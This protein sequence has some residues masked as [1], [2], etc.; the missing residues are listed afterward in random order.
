MHTAYFYFFPWITCLLIW[1]Y[2]IIP[3][4][5][6]CM[7]ENAGMKGGRE[8]SRRCKVSLRRGELELQNKP[9]TFWPFNTPAEPALECLWNKIILKQECQLLKAFRSDRDFVKNPTVGG[10]HQ[11][12]CTPGPDIASSPAFSPLISGTVYW[13]AASS[14]GNSH[15]N[16]DSPAKR[17]ELLRTEFNSSYYLMSRSPEK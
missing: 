2:Y 8:W 15:S 6:F 7:C 5:D 12:G 16:R 4:T 14:F 3:S 11:I 9:W 10:L 17:S 13:Q 1:V